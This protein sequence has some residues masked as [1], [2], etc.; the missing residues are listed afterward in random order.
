MKMDWSRHDSLA[1]LSRALPAKEMA[2][3]EHAPK[4]P[5]SSLSRLRLAY[6]Y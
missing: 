6:A 2:P 1:M 4:I 5:G 3:Q